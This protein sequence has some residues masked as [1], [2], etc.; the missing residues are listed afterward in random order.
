RT[1]EEDLETR[2]ESLRDRDVVADSSTVKIVP[3]PPT[4]PEEREGVRIIPPA[5][6]PAV[7]PAPEAVPVTAQ[8]LMD[9]VRVLRQQREGAAED[10]EPAPEAEPVTVAAPSEPEEPEA[11][12]AGDIDTLFENLRH[13][14]A[15]GGSAQR[16]VP[17]V[18]PDDL[19]ERL[20][21]PA[22]NRAHRL[23]KKQLTE[24]QNLTLE[25]LRV[26]GDDWIPDAGIHAEAFGPAIAELVLESARSGY[27]AAAELGVRSDGP[28][29]IV[30]DNADT[31][32]AGFASD[33]TDAVAEVLDTS[34]SAGETTRKTSAA[35]SRVYR[36]W[37]TDA[38]EHRLREISDV[39]YADALRT[40]L[41][42]EGLEDT[43][44]ALGDWAIARHAS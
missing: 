24:Q 26:A 44:W 31:Q 9:E 27:L 39:A 3:P 17:T 2:R 10:L 34:R 12:S 14:D 6:T 42:L 15:D 25:Q 5:D 4:E 11:A 30:A 38:A 35:A 29:D 16:A 20:L 40:A 23:I 18:D 36:A 19:R 28:P 13:S 32:V 8:E 1:M 43:E 7:T 22:Q 41:R 37:R 33:L 21:L